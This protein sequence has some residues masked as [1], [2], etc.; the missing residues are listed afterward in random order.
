MFLRPTRLHRKSYTCKWCHARV[1]KKLVFRLKDGPM[2]F[3]FCS[4]QCS[5]KWTRYRH[6]TLVWRLIRMDRDGRRYVLGDR[7]LD[8]YISDMNIEVG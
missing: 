3:L 2:D 6:N 1:E 7:S 8:N 4:D 5:R